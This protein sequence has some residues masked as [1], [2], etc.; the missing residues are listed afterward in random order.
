VTDTPFVGH[1]KTSRLPSQEAPCGCGLASQDAPLNPADW[2]S[3]SARDGA[4]I[5]RDAWGRPVRTPFHTLSLW[6]VLVHKSARP[7]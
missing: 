5:P 1:H 2:I 7:C 6:G 3:D 4:V